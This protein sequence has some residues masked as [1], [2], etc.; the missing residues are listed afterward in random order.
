MFVEDGKK[1]KFIPTTVKILTD[2]HCRV[3]TFLP[4]FLQDTYTFLRSRKRAS[5]DPK[6]TTDE[7]LTLCVG[8]LENMEVD[9]AALQ[10]Q[11]TKLAAENMDLTK[12]LLTAPQS[13]PE[14]SHW[15]SYQVRDFGGNG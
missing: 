14:R 6:K 7:E 10:K 3:G 5:G 2:R 11:V 12:Q 9:L 13:G 15:A 8:R 4:S 1:A